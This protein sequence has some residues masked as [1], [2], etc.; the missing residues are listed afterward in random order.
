MSDITGIGTIFNR[1]DGAQWQPIAKIQN[2][3]GPTMSRDT[4]E[5][6]TLD[7]TDGY[8]TFIGGLRDG[9]D[10][11]LPMNFTEA[12]YL[13]MKADFEDDEEQKYQ[14]V[15]P[16]DE[17]TTLEFEGLVTDLP[18]DIQMEEVISCDI[19]IKVS[20]KTEMTNVKIIESVETLSPISIA[21]AED[22]QLADLG[23]PT[24]VE[25]TME[26]ASTQ[27]IDVE[28][29]AGVPLFDG[30]TAGTYTFTGTLK[31][32]ANRINPLGL[33]AT[34]VANMTE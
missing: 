32:P 16:N 33:K 6:T 18:L 7:N 8:R 12:G 11:S 17:N 23:L 24:D 19:T 9:G 30:G 34:Q 13:A 21:A 28:W 14:I 29:N 10:V 2:I 4:V 3:G 1:W 15:L 27:Q 22:T 5:T 25:C 20:G 31:P 26:D